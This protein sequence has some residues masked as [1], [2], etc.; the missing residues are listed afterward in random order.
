MCQTADLDER[1]AELETSSDPADQA[2][3]TELY[4]ERARRQATKILSADL[5]TAFGD[6]K[7]T[8][9]DWPLGAEERITARARVEGRA[10]IAE[11][12]GPPYGALLTSDARLVDRSDW[13]RCTNPADEWVRYEYWTAEGRSAHGFA[14][15]VCRRVTQTG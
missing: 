7:L 5:H 1:I 4:R 12:I 2:E 9:R 3:L 11:A 10:A 14:C 15:P 8:R 13:C 6:V